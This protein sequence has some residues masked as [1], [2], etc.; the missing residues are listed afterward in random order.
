L[1]F[2]GNFASFVLTPVSRLIP[3]TEKPLSTPV[4]V[5][6]DPAPLPMRVAAT[7][8]CASSAA[9]AVMAVVTQPSLTVA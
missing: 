4:L 9:N 1:S 6:V 8:P 5:V 7:L 3:T 2:H